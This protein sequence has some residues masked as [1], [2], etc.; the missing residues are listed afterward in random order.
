MKLFVAG[1]TRDTR[2][3]E[4]EDLFSRYGNVYCAEIVTDYDNVSRGFA[5]VD[6]PDDKEAER[7][8]RKL[9]ARRWN[10]WRLK[11]S[12]ARNQ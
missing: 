9:D 6:M 12:K 4:L 5:F 11:V 1:F 8:I 10:G 2:D 7:A 3:S